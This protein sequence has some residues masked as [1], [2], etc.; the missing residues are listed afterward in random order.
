VLHG[1]ACVAGAIAGPRLAMAEESA[2]VEERWSKGGLVGS[3]ARPATGPARGPAALIIAGSGPEPRDGSFGTYLQVAKA[4]A[5]SGIRSLRYDKRMVG[6]SWFFFAREQDL[7]LQTFADDAVT[8]I[9]DLQARPDVSAVIVIGHSEGATLATLAAAKIAVAG[10]VLMAGPGRRF[11]AILREQIMNFTVAP[12]QEQYRTEALTILDQLVKGQRVANVSKPNM[13]LFRPSVQPFLLS[14]MAIDPAGEFG[15]LT[16]PALVVQGASDIQV[17]R[18]DFDALVKA[19][20]DAS[21]LLLP[22]TN[23]IFTAAPADGSNRAAQLKSY[24]RS[25]PLV[26]DLAPALV[27]FIQSVVPAP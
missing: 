18:M 20:P 24:D 6:A 13:V 26:P 16:I 1:V 3:F 7:T 2:M 23:H 5:A 12:D 22:R 15:R 17:S 27:K 14:F 19:R 8:A 21:S 10:I 4:L 9:R 11:D 25:A